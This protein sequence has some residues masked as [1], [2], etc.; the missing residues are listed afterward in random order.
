MGWVRAN[1]FDSMNS[2]VHICR[3]QLVGLTVHNSKCKR[4]E[5]GSQLQ[6]RHGDWL[7]TSCRARAACG[8]VSMRIAPAR[9]Q[10]LCG[11]FLPLLSRKTA[12]RD[13]V[14]G[15]WRA[16]LRAVLAVGHA[17]TE[18]LTGQQ[19]KENVSPP[20]AQCSQ[21]GCGFLLLFRQS[22]I[23]SLKGVGGFSFL[24]RFVLSSPSQLHA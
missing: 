10:T 11:E 7:N 8:V 22:F 6:R 19:A 14:A 23:L 18:K 9:I 2:R 13:T 16:C 15:T 21:E 24:S 20:I 17:R 3:V 12:L 5:F 1:Q 4:E